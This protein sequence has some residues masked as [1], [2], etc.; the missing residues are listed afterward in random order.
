MPGFV[1]V[2]RTGVS[3]GKYLRERDARG[4]LRRGLQFSHLSFSSR[5]ANSRERGCL[6]CNAM[7]PSSVRFTPRVVTPF[8][9]R[10]YHS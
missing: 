10:R 9:Q 5:V 2:I 6:A 8:F 1:Q 3:H 7:E 4:T